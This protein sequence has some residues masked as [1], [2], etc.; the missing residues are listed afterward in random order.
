[1]GGAEE[2]VGRRSLRE[3]VTS[4]IAAVAA[5][6]ITLAI[7]AIVAFGGGDD[8]EPPTQ[9]QAVNP[10]APVTASELAG[11]SKSL[12]QPVYWAGR[13]PG[14]KQLELTRQGKGRITVRYPARPG[15]DPAQGTLTVGTY[16]LD[17]A[18]AAIRRAGRSD[19]ARLY[20]LQGGGL[21]VYETSKPTNVYLAYPKQPYQVEVYDPQPGRA[22]RLVRRGRVEPVR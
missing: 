4:P 1:M 16:R 7:V 10:P 14:S 20:K 5:A 15:A 21:A 9:Q 3:W 18:L 12:G 8:E 17:D 22:L 13:Q 19:T 11:L 2:S 6:A